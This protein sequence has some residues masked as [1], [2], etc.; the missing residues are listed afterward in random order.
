MC[1][2]RQNLASL[3]WQLEDHA[4]RKNSNYNNEIDKR[5]ID[6]NIQNDVVILG[7]VNR[8]YLKHLYLNAY[9]LVFPSPFENFAYTLVEALCCSAAIVT[10]NTTA[11]PESC[12]D[13]AL[14]FSPDAEEELSECIMTFL[15]DEKVRLKYKE[16]ALLKSKEY[17]VYSEQTRQTNILLT[18]LL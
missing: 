10:T 4:T 14:Y 3:H 8:G 1:T 7:K 15:S 11:M 16:M 5:I 2:C 6:L 12:G 18:K 17:P 13:A 9:T